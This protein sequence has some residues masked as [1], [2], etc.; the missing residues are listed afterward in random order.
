MKSST[1]FITAIVVLFIVVLGGAAAV[2][3][4]APEHNP[5]TPKDEYFV[6]VADHFEIIHDKADQGQ[7]YTRYTY[8]LPGYNKDGQAKD[9]EFNASKELRKDAYLKISIRADKVLSYEE[10]QSK[11]LPQTVSSKM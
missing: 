9:I 11:D 2:S 10:V 4:Y 6:K 8:T 1:K 3:K 7:E 5:F